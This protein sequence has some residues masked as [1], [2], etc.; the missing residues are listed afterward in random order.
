MRLI[1]GARVLTRG[2]GVLQVGVRDPLIVSDLS[3]HER[4][5]LERLDTAANISLADQTRY[6]RLVTRLVTAGL[7]EQDAPRSRDPAPRATIND[8]GPVGCGIGLAL[9]RAGWAVAIDDDGRAVE[10]PR[11]TYDPGSLAATRQAAA[12][13]T[14]RRVLPHADVHAGRERSDVSIIVSHGAPLIEAAVALMA[15]DVPHLYV[16]TDER[17]AQ[18]GP[19]VIPGRSACGVCAGLMRT[20]ADPLWP[21]LSLQL[22]AGRPLALCGPDTAAQAVALVAGALEW[23]RSSGGR[24]TG[25]A[26]GWLDTLWTIDRHRPPHATAVAP[27]PDCGCG[28][29]GPVG[30]ELAARR[31]RMPGAS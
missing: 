6:A 22:T 21:V 19:V 1:A 28:A 11:G 7:I 4:R 17:G 8:G 25:S 9:A 12:A 27:H 10:T 31:A 16:T 24:S 5:F 15:G 2:D 18:V 29:T 3:L 14:I 13:D 20:L 23:W 26:P 30:D